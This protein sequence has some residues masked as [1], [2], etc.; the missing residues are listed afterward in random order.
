[1][2]DSEKAEFLSP[3]LHLSCLRN[4]IEPQLII[5]S[6]ER[7]ELHLRI[8]K[9]KYDMKNRCKFLNRTKYEDLNFKDLFVGNRIT[10]FS[11]HLNLVDY[12]DQYTSRMLGS[13]KERT[14]A[15][16]KPDVA[17]RLGEIID[18]IIHSGFTITKAKMMKLT[19][20]EA[21]DLH[22]DH[23]SKPYYN[24]L[25][26]FIT[27]G[28]V[29]AMEILGDDAIGRWKQ[30]LGPA[31]S[32]VAR[33][34]APNTIR[35]R[36]GSDSIRNVA[37]GP[38]SFASAASELELFFPSNGG[39][40]PTGTAAYTHCTCCV[41]KPHAIKEG[42]AG[43]IIKAILDGG[44]DISALQMFYMDR[45]NSEEFY[46]IYKGV[47]AEYSEMVVELCSGPCIA[48]EIRQID[49]EKVFRDYCGPSDPEIARYLRPGTLRAR[50]GKN[51]I[52]NA[53]HCTDLPEDGLLEVQV[54][55][56][57]DSDPWEG[58]A[59]ISH[60]LNGRNCDV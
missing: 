3:I 29:V 43:K 25:L 33:T 36:F 45:A 14:L 8:R 52:Q 60:A 38:D 51:K 17:L 5:I 13:S 46:A 37:H 15:L 21:M 18:M 49:P 22:A 59:A 26:E 4:K 39:R 53:V 19:R 55:K 44:F 9:Q 2:G 27:S 54:T 1:M 20:G 6:R 11:R 34:D 7:S 48:L 12:A 35:G 23:Q 40:G 50:F 57:K 16:L 47:V 10:I 41:I 58:Q 30:L 24:E 42:V 31:N 56:K 28:P 32:V